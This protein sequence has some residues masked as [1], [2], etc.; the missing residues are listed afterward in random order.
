MSPLERV[1]QQVGECESIDALKELY[2]AELDQWK[3][4]KLRIGAIQEAVAY[5]KES[6]ENAVKQG[7]ETQE[8][9]LPEF[10]FVFAPDAAPGQY[11]KAVWRGEQGYSPTT[12]DERDPRNAEALVQLMNE[13]LGVSSADAECMLAG[14]M[15]GWDV[16]GAN[17]V[18]GATAGQ[19]PAVVVNEDPHNETT[20]FSG[21][22]LRIEVVQK[23]GR[24]PGDVVRHDIS[25]LSRLPAVGTVAD[26][27]FGKD[28]IGVVASKETALEM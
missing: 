10:C 23:I 15:F 18:P 2:D 8:E 13:K 28:G 16:P 4:A 22:I 19:R 9:R 6:L 26:I 3:N 14:S 5:R 25:K 20:M 17:P 12:Y 27:R 24:D 21:T 1:L 7:A 11:V